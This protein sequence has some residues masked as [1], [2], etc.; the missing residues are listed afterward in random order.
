MSNPKVTT[1]RAPKS[2]R[3]RRLHAASRRAASRP[4]FPILDTKNVTIASTLQVMF[5]NLE[6]AREKLDALFHSLMGVADELRSAT[7]EGEVMSAAAQAQAD[8]CA[9]YGEGREN[10]TRT[11]VR[12]GDIMTHARRAP[13]ERE[14][15]QGV[16]KELAAVSDEGQVRP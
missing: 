10:L 6:T 3:V 1:S 2:P 15:R 12:L 16:G 11:L 13:T 5:W 14:A 7:A 9:V 4:S 8:A